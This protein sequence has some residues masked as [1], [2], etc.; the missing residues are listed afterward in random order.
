MRSVEKRR[1]ER[2]LAGQSAFH[3]ALTDAREFLG[4]LPA[5]ST[6]LIV[7]S[8]PYNNGK[9]YERRSTLD[10]YLELQR[11]VIEDCVRVLAPEGS[12]CWQVGNHIPRPG[13]VLPLDLVLHAEFAQHGLKLRNR[14]IW[15][16]EHGLHAKR[17]FSGRYEV[18]L[19]YTKSDSYYFDVDPVRVPQKYPGKRYHRGKRNGEYSSN[20]KGKNPGDVWLIPNVKHNHV[21]KT[22]H[23]CQFPV[24]LVER[25][26]LSTTRPNDLVVDPFAGV[27]STL[28]AA[29]LHDRRALGS[30]ID[31]AYVEVGR[32]RLTLAARGR[33][34]TRPRD[35][36]IYVPSPSLSVA[37]RPDGF[38]NARAVATA[39]PETGA[40]RELIRECLAATP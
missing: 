32:K 23:P 24:E 17:R 2:V 18:V 26:V 20:P 19:W 27:G 39:T 3:L 29:V 38:D 30:E 36:P 22:I 10:A 7:T 25:L 35:R 14:I 8:P 1:A 15:H 28:V 40:A 37:K 31:K 33:L 11:A 6:Q 12:I 21:E 34:K 5:R 9:P 4:V 16:Y 13:E